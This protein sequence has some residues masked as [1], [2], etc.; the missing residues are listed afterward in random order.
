[1]MASGKCV[2]LIRP[3]P[4]TSPP[5]VAALTLSFGPSALLHKQ[6]DDVATFAPIQRFPAHWAL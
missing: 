5:A 6:R 2:L 1:M 4:V 3:R